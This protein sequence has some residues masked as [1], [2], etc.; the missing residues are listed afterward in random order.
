MSN[1]YTTLGV[2]ANAT[3]SELKQAYKKLSMTHHPDKGGDAEQFKAINEAYSTLKDPGKRQQYDNPA[4]QGWQQGWAAGEDAPDI[5]DM[6]AHMFGKGFQRPGQAGRRGQDVNLT[7]PMTLEEIASGIK[8]TISVTVAGKE[9]I[10]QVDIPPGVPRGQRMRYAG[11]GNPGAVPG[12]LLLN[13]KEL[14]HHRFE[15]QGNDIYS[16]QEISVWEALIGTEKELTTVNERKIKYKIQPGSQP[17]SRVKLAHQGINQGH[18]YI[19]L[20]INVPKDLTD[21]QKQ[22]ILS[23]MNGQL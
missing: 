4:P 19:I 10:I 6:F 16:M 14:P 18:H 15:R 2:N 8:K 13:I 3:Q 23:I 12:D 7:M 20:H 11:E 22:V 5:S 9:K 1:Y 21:Q 17:E